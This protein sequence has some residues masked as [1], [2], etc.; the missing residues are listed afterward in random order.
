MIT[1]CALGPGS[2]LGELEFVKGC[3]CIADV[4]A[5]SPVRLQRLCKEDFRR[6]MGDDAAKLFSEGFM[7]SRYLYYRM[8]ATTIE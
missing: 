1:A 8:S 4:V 7:E 2:T 5:T 3:D 6:I